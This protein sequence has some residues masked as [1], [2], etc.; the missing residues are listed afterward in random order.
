MSASSP[1]TKNTQRER[2]EAKEQTILNAATEVFT[3]LG[4]DGSTMA[5]IARRAHIA[6]GTLYLYH[7]NKQDLLAVV[8]GNFW[9]DLTKGALVAVDASLPA[10]EQLEQLATYHLKALIQQFDM[11]GLTYRARLRHGE[12]EYQLPKIREYVRVFD[13]I[14]ERGISRQE[15]TQAMPLWQCRDVFYGALEYSARTLLLRE[16]QFDASVVNQLL[17]M[18]HPYKTTQNLA[19]DS[20]KHAPSTSERLANIE[21]QLALLVEREAN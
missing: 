12:P 14:I 18:F 3:A 8:V 7:K 16:A 6:E 5:E 1:N 13:Q 11:V 9:A 4:V 19:A 20:E 15:F 10:I 21:A 17:V 2:L